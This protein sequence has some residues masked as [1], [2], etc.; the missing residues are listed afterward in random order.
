VRKLFLGLAVLVLTVMLSTD[1]S[2]WLEAEGRYWFPTLDAN[3]RSST[4]AV[5]GTNIDL[6]EDLGLDD[7]ESFPEGRVTLNFGK[8]RLRYGFMPL[9]WDAT[10][11]SRSFSIDFNG[12][13]YASNIAIDTTLKADYHRLGYEYD[14]IDVLN[15]RFGVI[16]EVKYFD[17][18]AG[19]KS[20]VFDE[21]ESLKAPIPTLGLAAQ[22]GLPGMFSIAGEVTGIGLGSDLYLY[23]AEAGV[24]LTPAPFVRI[25]A[26]YRIFELHIEDDNDEA[27]LTLSGPYVMLKADF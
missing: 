6:V 16:F 3:F 27:T 8:H 10:D 12:K 4:A 22:F 21:A 13:A 5:L 7:S 14:F 17:F 19:L 25:S 26:G 2:A 18:E 15:N 1:A 23:D 24:V 20:S 9:E 11:T